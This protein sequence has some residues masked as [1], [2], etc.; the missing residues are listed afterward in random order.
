MEWT[1]S[2]TGILVASV[3]LVL[4]GC[5]GRQPVT[6]T[7]GQYEPMF[8]SAEVQQQ[9][10]RA[11]RDAES[12]EGAQLRLARAAVELWE[13]LAALTRD[14]SLAAQAGRSKEAQAFEDYLRKVVR[15]SRTLPDDAGE[16]A[17]PLDVTVEFEDFTGAVEDAARDQRFEEAIFAAEAVL[18][19]LEGV[20]SDHGPLAELQF[21]L[22]L[23]HLAEG[24]YDLASEVFKGVEANVAQAE[25]LA[26]RARVMREEIDLLQ[27]L[28][29]S[30]LRDT[31]A[32]GWALLEEGAV[33]DAANLG[34]QVVQEAADEGLKREADMLCQ[35]A[36][37]TRAGIIDG[38]VS[39]AIKDVTDGPPYDVARRLVDE[40]RDRRDPASA[41]QVED[42]IA[43]DEKRLAAAVS[44]RLEEDWSEAEARVQE[45]LAEE[46]YEEAV[47][48]YRRF[49]GT[50]L[51]ERAD[52]AAATTVD[53]VVREERRRA[54]DLFVAAQKESDP[55]RRKALLGAAQTILLGLLEA[56]PAS[57]YVDRVRS[58]LTAVGQALGSDE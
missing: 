35:A 46:S 17:A 42:A 38:L 16:A 6:P 44:G 8:A 31:L 56:Y 20:E 47:A 55:E 26:Q 45:L 14:A 10:D 32:R 50:D 51:E 28:P 1:L 24:R 19:Q 58:N 3:C 54:G 40:L 15:T 34:E 37:R 27:T 25:E 52:G 33:D 43:A 21:R 57:S 11:R 39:A 41:A 18:A 13:S 22:G 9:L 49:E 23:W 36:S 7:A 29:A 30:N 2:R 48:I 4:M 53:M 5:P 12:A